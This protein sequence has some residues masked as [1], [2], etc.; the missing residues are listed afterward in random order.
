MHA[1]VSKTRLPAAI[2]FVVLNCRLALLPAT[3]AAK[4]SAAVDRYP[5][6]HLRVLRAAILRALAQKDSR[7]VRVDPHLVRA[8]RNQVGLAR[9]LRNPEA[10]IGIGGKSLRNVGVGC[11]G[12][13]TGMCSSFA[14][15]IP[16]FG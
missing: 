6:K 16:S 11:A 3:H 4:S 5:Q 10:V 1:V 15:T 9:K 2:F 13:L 7:P 12:S 14:V 8:I